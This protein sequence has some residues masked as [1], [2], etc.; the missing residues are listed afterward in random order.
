LE[1]KERGI[2]GMSL[3]D[4]LEMLCD[5]KAAG[6]RHAD[7]CVKRSLKVNKERFKLSDQLAS[8]LHNT[9]VECGWIK[10]E[11]VGE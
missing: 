3:F 7:G 4:L 1:A 5:W 6:E 2:N 9:A 10:V 8:V 11:E